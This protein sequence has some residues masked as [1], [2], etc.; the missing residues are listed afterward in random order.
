ME[1]CGWI[2]AKWEITPNKRRARTYQLTPAGQRQLTKSH[3]KWHDLIA[4]VSK[5]LKHA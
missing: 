3:Q 5:V 1:Q 2:K 4:A